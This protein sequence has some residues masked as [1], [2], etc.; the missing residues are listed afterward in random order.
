MANATIDHDEIRK[1]AE[2]KGGKPAA[3]DRTHEGGDTGIIRIMFPDNPQSHHGALVE[4]SWDEFFEQFEESQLA[5]MYDEGSLF[6]KIIGRDTM[7]RREHGDYSSRHHTR[8]KGH[9]QES[10]GT[11]DGGS[12][13][14]GSREASSGRQESKGEGRGSGSGNKTGGGA[15]GGG[16]ESAGDLKSREYRDEKGEVHHH[17]TTYMEQHGGGKKG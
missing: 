14:G 13:G 16:Q 6:N 4:I 9:G 10:R 11:A 17:T 12:Q 7:E 8:G 2:S 15:K 5:L 3:V 1:W